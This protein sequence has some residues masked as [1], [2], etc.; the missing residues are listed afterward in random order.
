MKPAVMNFLVFVMVCLTVS[1]SFAD[2]F[3][4]R[5]LRVVIDNVDG[6]VVTDFTGD[7]TQDIL[8]LGRNNNKQKQLQIITLNNGQVAN[9]VPVIVELD[10]QVLFYDTAKLAGSGK[11]SLVFLL[12]G[13]VVRFDRVDH[14]LHT[15]VQ[16]GSIYRQSRERTTAIGQLK[17]MHDVNGDG[18]SDI[19]LP[20]FD[21][22]KV[23]IQQP[24]GSFS[25][26]Q[27]ID[28]LAERRLFRNNSA[29][30]ISSQ[31]YVSDFNFD[32]QIDLVYRVKSELHVFLQRNGVFATKALVIPMDLA[33]PLTD[34]YDNLDK[35]HS[36]RVTHSFYKLIDL[37]N[38]RVLDLITQVTKSSGLL[39]KTSQYQFYFG[40]KGKQGV[41][42][43]KQPHSV[44]SAPGL[45]F[46]LTLVDFDADE[47]L[48]LVSPS[49]DL[50]IGSIISSLFSSSADLDIAFHSLKN[51]NSYHSK[52]NLEKE[53]TVDFDLSSGQEVYPLLKVND[54]NGDGLKDLLMGYGT[55]KMYLYHGV[56]S[57][58]LFAR[59][60]Q[61]VSIK[62]PKNGQ[63]VAVK[64]LNNDGKTDLVIRYDKLDGK[65]LHNQLK[66]L[67]AQ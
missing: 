51:N 22:T 67:V 41:H 58:K 32:E 49:Y 64:D 21:Q 48:D 53:L 5:T 60:A 66:V 35:D 44:A 8:L 59:R 56:K 12:P 47:Q 2:P 27:A 36:D 9:Q 43:L 54:F 26:E 28:M 1:N 15:L 19:V 31:L 38:D 16:S 61:K 40:Q 62:L 33:L 30:Y 34:D 13:K 42:F 37:N 14:K 6:M 46:E 23:F 45:Q 65:S 52:P 50:G 63:F 11:T 7:D 55:K 4:I 17:L 39:D 29:V 18:L 3:D 25:A 57:K 10:D 24:N 20:D